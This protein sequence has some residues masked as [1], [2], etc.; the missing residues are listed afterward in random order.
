MFEVV[1]KCVLKEPFTSRY[2]LILEAKDKSFYIPINIGVFE[3]EAIYTALNQIQSPRPLTYDFFKGILNVI[4]DVNIEKITI[5]DVDGHVYKARLEFAHNSK[6]CNVDCRPSD[7][8]ALGLRLNAPIF[9]ED[10]IVEQKKCVSK[11]CLRENEK[12]ILEQLI[13][14]QATTYWNV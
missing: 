2:L 14:D 1:A 10:S 6:H 13:T 9:V 4:D 7:A 8:I 12:L 11:N 5:Y 3:A